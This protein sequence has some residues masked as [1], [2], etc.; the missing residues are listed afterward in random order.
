[1][2][3]R[4]FAPVESHYLVTVSAACCWFVLVISI[5]PADF[6][7]FISFFKYRLT[8]PNQ[9]KTFLWFNNYLNAFRISKLLGAL[10]ATM[11]FCDRHRHHPKLYVGLVL[12]MLLLRRNRG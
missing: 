4:R 6:F 10:S 7:F 12:A 8:D 5:Y 9:V 1:L 11:I 2:S 3:W